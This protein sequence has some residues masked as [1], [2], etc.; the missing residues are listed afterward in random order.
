MNIPDYMPRRPSFFE[1]IGVTNGYGELHDR[2]LSLLVA[3][4][5]SGGI[6]GIF[7]VAAAFA[8]H[9]AHVSCL[10][11]HEVTQLETRYVRSGANGE[12]YVNVD[13]QW[14]PESRWR[15]IED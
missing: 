14:I 8:N 4:V 1:R 9:T 15:L 2:V 10:R 7:A 11:L 12:C 3:I 6:A 5:I 13:G